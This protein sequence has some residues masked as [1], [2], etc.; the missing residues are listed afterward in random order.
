[1]DNHYYRI[2][3]ITLSLIL[4]SATIFAI[5]NIYATSGDGKVSSEQK[6]SNTTGGFTGALDDED[7]FG[8]FGITSLG[9]LDG[10]TVPDLAVGAKN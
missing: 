7:F 9:D 3:I 6:V 8:S 1:M 2:Y 4:F 10:D 5:P